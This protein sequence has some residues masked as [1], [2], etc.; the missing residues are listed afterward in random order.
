[1]VKNGTGNGTVGFAP[2]TRKSG[3]EGGCCSC[4][5]G[6]GGYAAE[7]GAETGLK[8]WVGSRRR[9]AAKGGKRGCATRKCRT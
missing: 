1:L 4:F 8:G 9:V 6:G 3:P 7:N 2:Q 5:G